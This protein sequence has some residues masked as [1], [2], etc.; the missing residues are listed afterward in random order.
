VADL[1]IEQDAILVP[2]RYI[3]ERLLEFGREY[4]LPDYAYR[5]AVNVAEIHHDALKLAIEKGVP[6]WA[7]TS[8]RR[9]KAAARRGA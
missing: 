8:P 5:K 1:M 4:G 6:I 2:T 9:A 3:I 7:P